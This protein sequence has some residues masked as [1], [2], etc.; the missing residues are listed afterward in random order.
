MLEGWRK[1]PSVFSCV[2][3]EFPSTNVDV[4][5]PT[6]QWLSC[7]DIQLT[8]GLLIPDSRDETAH[9]TLMGDTQDGS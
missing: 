7:R 4:P 2:F 5:S 6:W 9:G 1:A 8:I 3:R